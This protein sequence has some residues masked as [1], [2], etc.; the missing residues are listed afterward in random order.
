MLFLKNRLNKIFILETHCKFQNCIFFSIL[1]DKL[2]GENHWC[3]WN[4]Y[5]LWFYLYPFCGDSLQTGARNSWKILQRLSSCKKSSRKRNN[6]PIASTSS[7]MKKEP[8]P[9]KI[10]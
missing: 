10:E 5:I 7:L 2:F 9:T 3:A 6:I 4:V 1:D 8:L